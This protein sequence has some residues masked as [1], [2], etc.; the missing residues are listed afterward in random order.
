MKPRSAGQ[1]RRSP[2]GQD[3]A[4]RAKVSAPMPPAA[5]VMASLTSSTIREHADV[6]VR[7]ALVESIARYAELWSRP[8]LSETVSTR[9]STRLS[10][11]W[12]RT[13]FET[14]T[15]TLAATLRGDLSRLDEV[16]CHELAHIVAHE[17]SGRREGPHGPTWQ[18]LVRAGGFEP[19]LRLAH[20]DDAPRTIVRRP[21]RFL[22]RCPVCDFSRVAARPIRS[23]RCADCVAAGLGGNLV[24]T[25]KR[26]PA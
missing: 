10:K 3:S 21:S 4:A 22:H 11:S 24:I 23:W 16:L 15:I 2:T 8:N 20:G 1:F 5:T 6:Q 13:N 12:A 7:R 19:R 25:E 14:R 17:V 9:F 26:A 18:G